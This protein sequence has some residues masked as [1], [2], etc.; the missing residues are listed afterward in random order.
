MTSH[1]NSLCSVIWVCEQ[2][3]L[4]SCCLLAWASV[5]LNLFHKITAQREMVLFFLILLRG[6]CLSGWSLERKA[7]G[8]QNQLNENTALGSEFHTSVEPPQL[9]G[10][11]FPEVWNLLAKV[12]GTSSQHIKKWDILIT[13]HSIQLS[14]QGMQSRKISVHLFLLQPISYGE[15]IPSWLFCSDLF[16]TDSDNNCNCYV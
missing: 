12:V 11:C 2:L 14:Y 15:C 13:W 16:N 10:A 7:A 8:K 4:F 6:L 1:C 5:F 9:L 3:S